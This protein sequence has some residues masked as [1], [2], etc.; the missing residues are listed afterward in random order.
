MKVDRY[1][2]ST[3]YASLCKELKDKID[4]IIKQKL[5]VSVVRRHN[6]T[7]A[8][9]FRFDDPLYSAEC[10][11]FMLT[12]EGDLSDRYRILTFETANELTEFERS[13]E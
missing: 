13:T 12:D 3:E 6:Y 1:Q 11:G 9:S 7:V 4:D 8:Y 5:Y 10:L 2:D